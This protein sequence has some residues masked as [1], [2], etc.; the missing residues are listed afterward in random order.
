[1]GSQDWTVHQGHLA[2]MVNQESL[3]LRVR[4]VQQEV[5]AYQETTEYQESRVKTEHL[6]LRETW[7]QRVPQEEMVIQV[8]MGLLECR[9]RQGERGFPEMMDQSDPREIL[10]H[11]EVLVWT[12]LM[13]TMGRTECLEIQESRGY[14]V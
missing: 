13:E 10:D 6:D 12:E 4:L 8:Q 9:G 11:L 3:V 14:L 1:M 5:K 7:G 2:M